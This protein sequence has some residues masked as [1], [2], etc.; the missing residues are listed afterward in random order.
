MKTGMLY[1]CRFNSLGQKWRRRTQMGVVVVLCGFFLTAFHTFCG[2]PELCLMHLLTLFLSHFSGLYIPVLLLFW[3]IFCICSHPLLVFCLMYPRSLLLFLFHF[4]FKAQY[5]PVGVPRSLHEILL[6]WF[7][8]SYIIYQFLCCF[9][10]TS[11]TI[12]VFPTSTA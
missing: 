5:F 9:S 6:T 10:D 8:L 7:L 2:L 11:E 12:F 1:A 4:V 3:L